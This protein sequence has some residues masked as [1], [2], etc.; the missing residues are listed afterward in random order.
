M[1]C[2]VINDQIRFKNGGNCVECR[3]LGLVVYLFFSY[4]MLTPLNSCLNPIIYIAMSGESVARF[5]KRSGRKRYEVARK[6]EDGVSLR[7]LKS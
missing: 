7:V 4:V 3:S 5:S 2:L 6:V 1:A